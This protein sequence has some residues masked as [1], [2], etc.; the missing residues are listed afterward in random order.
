MKGRVI[1]SVEN[2][3]YRQFASEYVAECDQVTKQKKMG[4]LLGNRK[5]ILNSLLPIE[6][7][8]QLVEKKLHEASAADAK[9][10]QDEI[11]ESINTTILQL[12]KETNKDLHTLC[13]EA[14]DCLEEL[15]VPEQI[16][17]KI[18]ITE[19][20]STFEVR[21]LVDR[22][23]NRK[24]AEDIAGYAASPLEHK[25]DQENLK[26]IVEE[27]NVAFKD[28]LDLLT[29]NPQGTGLLEKMEEENGT[30]L[31]VR[32]DLHG[33]LGGSFGAT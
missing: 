12:R 8:V 33:D 16:D 6:K 2:S 31:F 29:K 1:S 9:K 28:K 11:K 4:L 14:I 7:Q 30:E 21:E 15:V 23:K 17:Q 24:W 26:R 22:F 27:H 25:Q 18:D 5:K 32:A 10:L 3:L 19:K 20:K 13:V